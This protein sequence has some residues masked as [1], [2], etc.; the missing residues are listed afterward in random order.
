MVG[1]ISEQH[2]EVEEEDETYI[3]NYVVALAIHN[4]I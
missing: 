3:C 1:S 2:L 4:Y